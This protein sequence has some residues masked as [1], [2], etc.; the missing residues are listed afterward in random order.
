[1]ITIKK[2][3][4]GFLLK[5]GLVGLILSV[6]SAGAMAQRGSMAESGKPAAHSEC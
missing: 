6:I 4:A 2:S 3:G 5:T 1:M